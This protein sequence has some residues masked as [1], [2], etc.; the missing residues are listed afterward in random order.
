[1]PMAR[2]PPS[3]ASIRH[4]STPLANRASGKAMTSS[5]AHRGSKRTG[6]W[7]SSAF[8]TML[9]NGVLVHN[10]TA[11]LGPMSYRAFPKYKAHAPKGPILLQDHG[12]PV[13]FRNI[14][15]REL[16]GYDQP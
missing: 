10:H 7:Y 5:S 11:I 3:T 2:P 15:V 16:K 4:W 13:R 9:H 12:H 8:V 1:M 6:R 14:W